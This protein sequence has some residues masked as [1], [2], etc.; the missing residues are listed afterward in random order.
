MRTVQTRLNLSQSVL[1]F[2]LRIKR[3]KFV[4]LKITSILRLPIQKLIFITFGALS[5]FTIAYLL[6]KSKVRS[7]RLC[8]TQTVKP[9]RIFRQGQL[10]S[11]LQSFPY[12]PICLSSLLDR[13]V[14]KLPLISRQP[15]HRA[16]TYLY[17]AI[18]LRVSGALPPSSY[19]LAS[20]RAHGKFCPSWHVYVQVF[21]VFS[22][23]VNLRAA[24][25][26]LYFET[27]ILSFL[28]IR[29]YNVLCSPI[30]ALGDESNVCKC[31]CKNTLTSKCIGN[32]NFYNLK[33]YK[34]FLF[35]N[36]YTARLY[37][38]FVV[39]NILIHAVFFQYFFKNFP[40]IQTVKGNIFEG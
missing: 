28:L 34:I 3:C 11:R 30:L 35:W 15:N 22:V 32:L 17:P 7:R 14:G 36:I 24:R 38:C 27:K 20:W 19:D 2:I 23:S 40:E 31:K 6:H 5:V 29:T 4:H 39:Y 16:A 1:Q 10:F 25:R 26:H 9:W 12:R 8:W 13:Q 33:F 21:L 37:C 18:R